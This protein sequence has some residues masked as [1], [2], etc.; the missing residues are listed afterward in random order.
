MLG[1]ENQSALMA[2]K[3]AEENKSSDGDEGKE[4]QRR[5]VKIWGDKVK[6]AKSKFDDDYN[7]MRENMDFV[8]GLQWKGQKK[9][10]YSRYVVNMTLRAVNQGVATLY[11]RNPRVTAKRRQRLDFQV[12]DGNMETVL[13]ATVMA[14]AM[15]MQ[16][17]E[18]PV[19]MMALLQD[20]QEGRQRQKLIERVGKTL[21]TIYQYQ[22]DTQQPRF[23]TQMK[24]LVRRVR[25]CGVG[26]IKVLFCREEQSF[27]GEYY[28]DLT[29][30]QTRLSFTDRLQQIK[31]LVEKLEKGD[32]TE[33]DPEVERLRE[34]AASMG[35]SPLDNEGIR[36]KE[37]LVFDFPIATSVI[38]DP[39]TRMLKGFVGA[40]WVAEEFYYPLEFVN[41]FFELDIKP[42]SDIK[43]FGRDNKPEEGQVQIGENQDRMKK[44]VRLWR[45]MDLDT[46]N[47]FTICD[48]YKDYVCEPE[49][50]DPCSKG[51]WNIVPVTFNDIEVEDGCIS[52]IFPPSDVDLL[53][54]VQM[55]RN[56]VRD[57]L[58]RHRKANG[59]RYLYPKGAISEEDLDKIDDSTDQQMVPLNGLNPNQKPSDVFQPFPTVKIEPALYDTAPLD[60]DALLATGQQEAN[61]GPAQ[62]NVTATNS[63]ISEQSRMSVAG[64]DVDG[65]DDSLTDAAQCGGE[66]LLREMSAETAKSIAGI[67][68]VWPEDD[69]TKAEFINEI[70]L[71]V[72]AAS[73]GR[74]NKII[75]VDN[76]QKLAPL[77]MQAVQMLTANPGAMP[78][79]QAM[80]RESIKRLDD[81]LDPADFFPLPPM[82][83][84][85]DEGSG[86]Q[87]QRASGSSSQEQ[88]PANPRQP[89][90]PQQLSGSYAGSA[91]PPGQQDHPAGDNPS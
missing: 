21:E 2:P 31:A 10:T 11:A 84:S 1:D 15:Q 70:D 73:S 81:N 22:M 50:V 12:W 69:K 55:E 77:I 13:Q 16:G 20:F 39:Q 49:V 43:T 40:H 42:D 24:Q 60:E 7:R 28:E 32:I 85:G 56:R 63:A 72:I 51:F 38:P 75:E 74:P 64:S 89:R 41:A 61:I 26:Y 90:R 71:E 91:R 35:T 45:I 6:K 83:P 76:W 68:A 37:R 65:L 30:S 44:K 19:E 33:D 52:T 29:Q 3:G 5:M 80:I 8:A 67:G 57:A 87:Q 59:P 14:Q 62:P 79:I 82:M 46:K 34:L 9:M 54:P 47:E 25:V 78:T 48:G 58:A 23:K 18:V 27:G 86:G 66:L 36:I 53:R 4:S 88:R 17:M